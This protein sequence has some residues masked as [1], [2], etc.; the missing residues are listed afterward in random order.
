MPHI[1][2]LITRAAIDGVIATHPTSNI[3]TPARFL[4]D[5]QAKWGTELTLVLVAIAAIVVTATAALFMSL[6]GRLSGVASEAIARQLRD[7]LARH[8]QHVPMSWHDTVQ[9]GDIVQ[10][11]TSDVDTV[12]L[13]YREQVIQIAQAVARVAIG[14]PILLWLDWKMARSLATGAPCR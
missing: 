6:Q 9:T 3:S 7:R 2:P 1:T 8:L 10:R 14:F 4:A 12:R 11:C 13:F 5:H